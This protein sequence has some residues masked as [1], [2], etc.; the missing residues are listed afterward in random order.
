MIT[1][2]A[3]RVSGCGRGRPSTRAPLDGSLPRPSGPDARGFTLVEMLMAM[4][5]TL[6]MMAAVVT[7]FANVSEQ[8]PQ[9][10]G[11][12]RDDQPDAARPQRAAAGPAGRDLPGPHLAAARVEPRLHRDHRRR[13]TAI[14]IRAC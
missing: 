7:L 2:A 1:F 14:R 11:D 10:P 12:D 5:I 6:V 13:S 9:S 8:R 4:A 3:H